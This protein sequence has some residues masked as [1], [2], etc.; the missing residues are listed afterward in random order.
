[1]IYTM[2]QTEN[3]A[4]YLKSRLTFQE[5][6]IICSILLFS[7]FSS[8]LSISGVVIETRSITVKL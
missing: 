6:H 8:F 7:P 1:M 5:L 3:A 4:L 2:H